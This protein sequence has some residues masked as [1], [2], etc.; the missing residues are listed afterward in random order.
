MIWVNELVH[1]IIIWLLVILIV[2]IRK[3]SLSPIVKYSINFAAMILIFLVVLRYVGFY[4][5]YSVIFGVI[6]WATKFIL[7]WIALYWLVRAI[8]VLD[9]KS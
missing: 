5:Q 3:T 2:Y 1:F 8:K 6:E 7:P 9:K 4:F